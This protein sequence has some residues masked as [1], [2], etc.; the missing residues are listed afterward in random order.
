MQAEIRR[1]A[2]SLGSSNPGNPATR[3]S[4]NVSFDLPAVDAAA[5]LVPAFS[6]V[7]AAMSGGEF[8]SG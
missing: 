4:R 5:D 2:Q 3:K 6:A 7:L 8:G 1:P